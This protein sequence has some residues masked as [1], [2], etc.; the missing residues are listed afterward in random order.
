[1]QLFQLN[2]ILVGSLEANA[3]A[4]LAHWQLRLSQLVKVDSRLEGR[5][6]RGCSEGNLSKSTWLLPTVST[7]A[8][9]PDQRREM[10]FE[11]TLCLPLP[12]QSIV[13]TLTEKSDPPLWLG[14]V[15]RV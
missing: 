14:C 5:L 10:A 1:M 15:A 4:M 2:D 8:S 7:R 13:E 9:W 6:Q 12:E 3:D 11:H